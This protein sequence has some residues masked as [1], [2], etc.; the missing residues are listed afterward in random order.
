MG[1]MD[2]SFCRRCL[3]SISADEFWRRMVTGLNCPYPPRLTEHAV[4][5]LKK[6][7][8]SMADGEYE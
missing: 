4:Q 1:G 3:T 2:Y 7:S 6:Y 8:I 5:E